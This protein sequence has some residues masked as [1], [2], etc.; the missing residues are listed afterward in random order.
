VSD[1]GASR[2]RFGQ[3]GSYFYLSYA[4]SPPLEGSTQDDRDPWVP[5]FFEDLTK[6][7]EQQAS[8]RSR[9]GAGFFDREI[10]PGSDWS[11]SLIREL[12]V[13][14]VLVPL[15]SPGYFARSWPG[16]EWNCF[17]QRVQNAGVADPLQRF[18]P[19]L[20]IPLL[21]EED[22]PALQESMASLG[23]V[24][25]YAENG[26]RALLRL[27]FYRGSYKLVVRRL[28]SRIVELAETAPIG[29]SAV[30]DIDEVRSPFSPEAS[31]VAF[32]ISVA[33]PASSA[34]PADRDRVG[35]GESGVEWR[36][37]PSEQQL[38]LA[39]YAQRIAEQMDF[40]GIVADVEKRG[41]QLANR[42]GVVL[43]D[44]WF[45][46]DESGLR[47]LR[48]IVAKLPNWVLPLL[49]ISAD[50]DERSEQL[51]RQVR[52][53]L[54]GKGAPRSEVA[55]RASYG[56]RSLADFAALMPV[57][58]AEAE[59]QYL[60]RDFDPQ[61]AAQADRLRQR[62]RASPDDASPQ[63]SARETPDA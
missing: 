36:P 54:R 61:S 39:E 5:Q 34:V 13:A 57:L 60:R 56:V 1:T 4:Q 11:A 29:P 49:V 59:R 9:L 30:P 42:P 51:E 37:Y 52:D 18:V 21:G 32:G 50:Q 53:I 14:E 55:L 23:A 40:A 22:P 2:S 7:V 16:R 31:G 6:A 44:P 26:M 41:I 47:T 28:A 33:A 38:P 19:V 3:R 24:S 8:P 17:Y 62:L 27:Q 58:A 10:P 25:D 12:G 43:I 15:Y 35:Y 46:A 63:N 45:I 20:W 48:D